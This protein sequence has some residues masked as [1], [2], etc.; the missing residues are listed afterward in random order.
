MKAALIRSSR[1]HFRLSNKEIV[2][3][4]LLAHT[5]LLCKST[6]VWANNLF[7]F[8]ETQDTDLCFRCWMAPLW[9]IGPPCLQQLISIENLNTTSYISMTWNIAPLWLI[10]T[11]WSSLILRSSLTRAPLMA[12]VLLQNCRT[13]LQIPAFHC[14]IKHKL[15]QLKLIPYFAIR[16]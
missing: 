4:K 7:G 10:M 9:E 14:C 16:T 6:F 15:N 13:L 3:N 12:L 11:R 8:L 5:K 1:A 2:S